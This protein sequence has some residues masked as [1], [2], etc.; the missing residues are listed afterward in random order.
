VI[1]EDLHREDIEVAQQESNYFIRAFWQSMAPNAFWVNPQQKASC[2]KI[3]QLKA[4]S[5]RGLAIPMTL[6]GNDPVAIRAFLNTPGATVYKPFLPAVWR[7]EHKSYNLET[8]RMRSDLLPPD[9][10]LRQCPCIFQK[11]V[12]KLYELRVTIMGSSVFCAKLLTQELKD[13]NRLDW[14]L[15]SMTV[16]TVSCE[17][18]ESIQQKCLS[19]MEYF[20]LVFGTFDFIVTPEGEHIFLEI[21]E[22]GQFLWLEEVC[23]E[24][25]L[26]DAFSEFLISGDPKFQ[27][28]AHGSRIALARHLP[29]VLRQVHR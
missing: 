5:E 8:S 6:M 26:L 2:F 29:T 11:E 27:Y 4:A 1:S 16:P 18:P 9:E 7:S 10:V 12:E 28:K 19:L 25:P 15:K 13:K 22:M 17:L 3:E 20:G 23:S 14:R 24:L 21:N